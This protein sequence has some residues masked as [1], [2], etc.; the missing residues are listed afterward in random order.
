MHTLAGI[1]SLNAR[2]ASRYGESFSRATSGSIVRLDDTPEAALTPDVQ[3]SYASTRVTPELTCGRHKYSLGEVSYAL[4]VIA[5][6]RAG[7][8]PGSRPAGRARVARMENPKTPD[9]DSL[10]DE[11][12][13]DIPKGHDIRALG[14]SDSSDTGA[15]MVGTGGAIDSTTDRNGT[16]ERASVGRED[17]ETHSD[18]AADRIVDAQDVGL[19]GGLDQAEEAQ[20]GIT[21][22]EIEAVVREEL[23]LE[24]RR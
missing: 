24:P 21:D 18:V 23:G 11:T 8:C 16:G 4:S 22:E 12:G 14:P 17:D 1:M 5:E 9:L 19:G 2:D 13:L 3:G 15:D 7:W 6:C 10:L 20:L